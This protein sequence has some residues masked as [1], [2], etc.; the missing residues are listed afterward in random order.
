M[1]AIFELCEWTI[2]YIMLAE[3]HTV[4]VLW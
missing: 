3:V 1:I 4:L 2:S